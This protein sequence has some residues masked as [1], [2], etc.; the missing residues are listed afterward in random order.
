M[1]TGSS[2]KKDLWGPKHFLGTLLE[3]TLFS[4]RWIMAPVYLGMLVTLLVLAYKFVEELI[5]MV[6]GVVHSNMHEITLEIL[7]LL[8]ITLLA[9]LILIV[10][11]SGYENFVSKIGVAENSEDRP[12]WM[13][14]V[15][16]SG[17]KIKLV[18]SLVAISVIE[19]LKDFM[20]PEAIVGDTEL[21]RVGIH[22]TFV[23]SGLL[24]ALMDY[25]A[26]MRHTLNAHGTDK[27]AHVG[28]K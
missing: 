6:E 16:Y 19:L 21:W 20:E 2:S 4:G 27:G 25:M 15:D 12:S 23:V 10:V 26:D 22:L 9:N 18:G 8:D 17:L 7:G 11:F 14:H 28:R 5:V 13:G 3:Y 1:S 24:F